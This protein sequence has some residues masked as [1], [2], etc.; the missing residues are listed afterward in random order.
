MTFGVKR[1]RIHGSNGLFNVLDITTVFKLF[2]KTS[3]R[4]SHPLNS[5][6]HATVRRAAMFIISMLFLASDAVGHTGGG[7]SSADISL[8]EKLGSHIPKDIVFSDDKGRKVQLAKMLD[9]PVIIAPVYLSCTHTCPL[10]LAGLADALG[11]VELVKPG[12]DFRVV[13]VS[14]DEKDTPKVARDKKSN[15][16]AAAGRPFPSEAWTFLTGDSMNIRKFTDA[17]GFTIQKD[18][19]EFS[20]PIAV[21]VVSPGGRIVR[22]LYGVTFLPFDLTMAVTEAAEGKVGSTARRVLTYCFSYDPKEKSY[23]FNILKVTGA[24][25]VLFV[26]S[27]FAY[28]AGTANK[29]RKGP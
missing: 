23:V 12:R 7:A 17:I 18:G 16:L 13:T 14:F 15:Y 3:V 19:A 24:V 27:F 5:Q 6:E 21:I 8:D 20:H 2:L 25:V 11:K 22:Y 1:V 28:L 9:R 29:K 4:L 10:L 26:A